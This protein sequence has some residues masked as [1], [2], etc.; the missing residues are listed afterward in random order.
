MRNSDLVNGIQ[1]LGFRKWYERK[2]LTS[3]AHMVLC[4]LAV[5]GLLGAFEAM[6]GASETTR[7]FNAMLAVV[8][9]GTGL[10]ALRRYL[11]LLSRAEEAANQA[12]CASC[13][14]YGRFEVTGTQEREGTQ[15]CC[16]KCR[17]LWII[18]LDD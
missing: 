16:R 8:C 17:H 15:V 1:S 18:S 2:L 14:E 9:A 12:S 5:I 3:H 13:G 6:R 10:W 4:F 11:Y 7:M